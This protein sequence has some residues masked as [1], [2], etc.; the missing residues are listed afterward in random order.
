MPWR[1]TDY[2]FRTGD[3]KYDSVLVHSPCGTIFSDSV[4]ESERT[5]FNRICMLFCQGLSAIP[6]KD[7]DV[8]LK[9]STLQV[10][11][12]FI[13][14]S[15]TVDL[16]IQNGGNSK[17]AQYIREIAS[18]VFFEVS[19]IKQKIYV[20]VVELKDN[21]AAIDRWSVDLKIPNPL[22]FLRVTLSDVKP[23]TYKGI[24]D[25]PLLPLTRKAVSVFM[26]MLRENACLLSAPLVKKLEKTHPRHK[27]D[28]SDS[29]LTYIRP[30]QPIPDADTDNDLLDKRAETYSG[31]LFCI[32]EKV[33]QLDF[34]KGCQ[35]EW[36]PKEHN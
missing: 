17:E 2:N 20:S 27:K 6:K 7:L 9:C 11:Y 14:I 8:W 30:F 26:S 16:K 5:F 32:G 22:I 3:P 36:N 19:G 4:L 34:D 15:Q 21:L 35:K 25:Q 13:Q 1:Y 12:M 18:G 33:Y 23:K 31:R 10:K 24:D 29:F 28:K